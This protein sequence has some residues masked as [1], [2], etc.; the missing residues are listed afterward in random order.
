MGDRQL[1]KLEKDTLMV[2]FFVY[3]LL[4]EGGDKWQQ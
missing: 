3:S 4:F 1:Q 2:S